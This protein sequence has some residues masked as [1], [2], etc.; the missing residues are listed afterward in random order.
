MSNIQ[1]TKNRI[2]EFTVSQGPILINHM[3]NFESHARADLFSQ[4]ASRCILPASSKIVLCGDFNAP[5]IDWSLALPVIST[6]VNTQLC[7]IVND[8]FLFQFV[9]VPT[10]QNHIL[11]L[12]FSNQPHI[13][14]DVVVVDNLPGTDHLA[15]Q[16]AVTLPSCYKS[17]CH[18][19]R[20]I[21]LFK[22]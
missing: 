10:C 9:S 12:V 5:H 1:L 2:D 4:S 8:N 15:L 17:Q 3:N 14:F 18:R 21:Q 13:L 16:F 19:L 6:P 7:S 22:D 20:I 11:D